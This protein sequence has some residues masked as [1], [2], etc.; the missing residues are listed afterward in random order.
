MWRQRGSTYLKEEEKEKK[1]EEKRGEG[2]SGGGRERRRERRR[3]PLESGAHVSRQH[4]P[5]ISLPSQGLWMPVYFHRT[6]PWKALKLSS[7][8]SHT[9][10][11]KPHGLFLPGPNISCEMDCRGGCLLRES[12]LSSWPING[13]LKHRTCRTWSLS[14]R[15]V[16]WEP[17][18]PT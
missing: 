16:S 15:N 11:S 10:I 14:F 5:L 8:H 2:E 17:M 1:E 12:I 4:S 7:L 3:I 13:S 6:V 9:D 18:E